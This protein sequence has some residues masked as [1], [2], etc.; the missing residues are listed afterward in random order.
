MAPA[1][2]RGRASSGTFFQVRAE[3]VEALVNTWQNAV[4]LQGYLLNGALDAP[5]SMT[6]ESANPANPEDRQ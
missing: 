6:I 1:S 5:G 4:L 3:Y 2:P